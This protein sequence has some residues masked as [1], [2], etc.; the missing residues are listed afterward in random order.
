MLAEKVETR[1]LFDKARHDGFAYFQGYFFRR[2]ELLKAREIPANQLN[3]LRMLKAV[4][5]DEMDIRELETLIK[6]EASVL[7]RWLRYLNSPMFGMRN[8]IR[9][10]RHALAILGE[11]EIRRW[12]RLVALVSAGQTKTSDLLLSALVRARFC[13]LIPREFREKGRTF[14]WLECSR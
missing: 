4:S 3:Y 12:I 2:P 11:R 7:Y 9:S 8:E 5:R 1:E 13:E 14:S 10:I 6:S